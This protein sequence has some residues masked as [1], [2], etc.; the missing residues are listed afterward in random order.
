MLGGLVTGAFLLAG[1]LMAPCWSH[2]GPV[3]VDATRPR[4]QTAPAT[5]PGW[6]V[7]SCSS[8]PSARHAAISPHIPWK[9]RRKAVL[10][11]TN[12]QIGDESDLGPAPVPNRPF[13]VLTVE[14]PARPLAASHRLRC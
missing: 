5:S 9:S 1:T 14:A 4:I 11:Q 6:S 3:K 13:S 8:I 2:A 10:E 7:I 12:P